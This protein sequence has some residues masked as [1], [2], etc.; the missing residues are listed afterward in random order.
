MNVHNGTTDMYR[1]G[2]VIEASQHYY[3]RLPLFKVPLQK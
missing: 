1:A 3:S 2:D